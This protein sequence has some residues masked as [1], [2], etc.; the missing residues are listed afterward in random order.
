M[1]RVKSRQQLVISGVPQLSVLRT[2]LSNIF[3]DDL[4][5]EIEC[6]LNKPADDVKLGRSVNL[7]EGRKALQRDL[8]RLDHWAEANGMKFNKTK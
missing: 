2:I 3:L 1:N 5:E 8:D 4:D 7:P 6:T